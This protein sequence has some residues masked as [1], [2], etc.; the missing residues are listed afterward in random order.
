MATRKNY[1]YV[2]V[3]TSEGPKFVTSIPERNMAEYDMLKEPMLFSSREF[4]DDVSTGLTM[5]FITAYTIVSKYEISHQPYH[6]EFGT[7]EW[8]NKKSE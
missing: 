2:L 4:A 7:F 1:Y 5:N 3:L 6:Y 8:V